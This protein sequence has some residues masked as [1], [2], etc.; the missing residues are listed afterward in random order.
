MLEFVG[1]ITNFRHL[2][3]YLDSERGAIDG[4]NFIIIKLN[5]LNLKISHDW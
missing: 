5:Y 3:A 4:P 1:H 2:T